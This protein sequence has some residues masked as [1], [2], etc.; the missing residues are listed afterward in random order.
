MT[1]KPAVILDLEK[2]AQKNNIDK[3]IDY[4]SISCGFR[5]AFDLTGNYKGDKPSAKINRHRKNHK[6]LK[7]SGKDDR[8][9]KLDT[10]QLFWEN[11]VKHISNN[12]GI[13]IGRAHV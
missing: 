10:H 1:K 9:N 8:A 5:K 6:K 2:C 7:R 3:G 13:Q 4:M 11:K 12:V